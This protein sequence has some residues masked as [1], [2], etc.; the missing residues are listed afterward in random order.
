M[1]DQIPEMQ[2]ATGHRHKFLLSLVRQRQNARRRFQAP[3]ANKYKDQLLPDTAKDMYMIRAPLANQLTSAAMLH[4]GKSMA[5]LGRQLR[6][7]ITLRGDFLP[8]TTHGRYFRV[9]AERPP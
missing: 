4:K 9:P 1:T 3:K 6:F 5:N 8:A 7:Q 2:I